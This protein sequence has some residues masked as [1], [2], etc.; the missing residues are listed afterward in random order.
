MMTA[1]HQF[2]PDLVELF[3][4]ELDRLRRPGTWWT[5]FERIAIAREAREVL[6]LLLGGPATDETRGAGGGLSDDLVG[7]VAKI[8]GDSGRLT[9]QWLKQL[10][11]SGLTVGQYVEMVGVIAAIVTIDTF[12]HAL[13]MAVPDLG[14][15]VAGE[16]TQITPL[17]TVI[18]ESWVPT[19]PPDK[20]EGALKRIYERMSQR[21]GHVANVIRAMTFVPA[22][23]L[24]F[25]SLAFGMYMKELSIGRA[26]IEFIAASVSAY[27]DCFY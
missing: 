22:E 18:H 17:G 2:R 12:H 23:Q 11:A 15:P 20:A 14:E 27:N 1:V 10:L 19:L 24:G 8:V 13:G 16:P 3:A 5:G 9:R 26:Q 21:T 7:A 4:A 6:R 25:M